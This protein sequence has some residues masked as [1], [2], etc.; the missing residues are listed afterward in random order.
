MLVSWVDSVV[1]LELLLLV[2]LVG[3]DTDAAADVVGDVIVVVVV[4]VVG[5]GVD[6]GGGVRVGV[7]GKMAVVIAAERP[8]SP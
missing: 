8:S 5:A 6:A 1:G 2:G 3:I 7:G 4:V